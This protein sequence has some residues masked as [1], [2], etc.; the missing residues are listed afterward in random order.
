M[1]KLFII[2]VT[3]NATKWLSECLRSTRGYSVIVVD[4][5]SNDETVKFI[6]ANYPEIILLEQTKN[7]GFGAANNIGISYALKNSADYVLLL[8]QDAYLETNTIKEL[9]D[10]H[11]NNVDYGVLSPV[12]LNGKGNKLDIGFSEYISYANNN[13][14][15]FDA[16]KGNLNDV[17]KVPFVNAACWLIPKST[18]NIIGGFDP[19]YFHY[20]ED[21]NYCH[22][23]N[24]HSLK[25]GVVPHVFVKH[26]RENR[27]NSS[28]VKKL[29][30]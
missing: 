8:N 30:V 14:L 11:K 24:Y 4:N 13:F 2:I 9:I 21:V 22:R 12:H 6:K 23:L 3:Y 5:D 17:Y 28:S 20:G 19:L 25:I 26:D 16:L 29:W 27:K 10:I 15:Y 18:L 7:L 1:E